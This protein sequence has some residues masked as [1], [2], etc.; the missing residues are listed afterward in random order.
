[1]ADAVRAVVACKQGANGVFRSAGLGSAW[2]RHD[3]VIKQ[4]PPVSE[5]AW[6]AEA[7]DWVDTCTTTPAPWGIWYQQTAP[8][9][10]LSGIA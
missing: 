9:R 10:R 8:S 3:D 5:A 4:V 1:M 2:A 6:R 7:N